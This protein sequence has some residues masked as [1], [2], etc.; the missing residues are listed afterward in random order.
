MEGEAPLWSLTPAF[1]S[2]MKAPGGAGEGLSI[3]RVVYQ[4]SGLC[5][6]DTQRSLTKH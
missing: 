5:T 2:R 4:G 3:G 1:L 6:I